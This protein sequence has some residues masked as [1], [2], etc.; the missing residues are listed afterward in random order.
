MAGYAGS[1]V[2]KYDFLRNACPVYKHVA[3]R[4][5]KKYDYYYA[6]P[7][8]TI[9]VAGMCTGVAGAGDFG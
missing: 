5:V 1:N 7:D 8:V 6:R 3:G 2:K 4:V 9:F